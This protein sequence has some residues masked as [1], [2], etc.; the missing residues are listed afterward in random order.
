GTNP[1][2]SKILAAGIP[3]GIGYTI[4]SGGEVTFQAMAPALVP[5]D[6]TRVVPFLITADTYVFHP[7]VDHLNVL[8]GATS[9]DVDGTLDRTDLP[10][11][12]LSGADLQ[13]HDGT[14]SETLTAVSGQVHLLLGD[15][16]D[17][18]WIVIVDLDTMQR[19]TSFTLVDSDTI[20]GLTSGH[21]YLVVYAT[22][23][24]TY[25]GGEIVYEVE[26]FVNPD[27]G[28][29]DARLVVVYHEAGDLVYDLFTGDPVYGWNGVQLQY[30]ANDPVR[31]FRGEAVRHYA[32]EIRRY[33]GGH[34]DPDTLLPTGEPIIDEDG[35][36]VVNGDGTIFTA[37]PG[38]AQ[39]H[40]REEKRVD[41]VVF[42][43]V[44]RVTLGAT[45]SPATTY[46]LGDADVD[47]NDFNGVIGATTAMTFRAANST[48]GHLGDGVVVVIAR[49]QYGTFIVKTTDWEFER[50]TGTLRVK[51]SGQYTI[52]G[53]TYDAAEIG[54]V[55]LEV[56]TAVQRFHKAGDVVRYFG[57]EA[58]VDFQP[59]V[60]SAGELVTI[61]GVVVLWTDDPSDA[62]IAAGT[63]RFVRTTNGNQI[64]HRRGEP[65]YVCVGGDAATGCLET[66]ATWQVAE[67]ADGDLWLR[68]GNEAR[69]WFGG[70]QAL[71]AANE[72]R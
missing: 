32:G 5:V 19:A 48:L 45:Y 13:Y 26:L 72:L 41:V 4:A 53:R 25:F 21:D 71:Y 17:A 58:V 49:S 38:Q 7:G 16:V 46:L 68:L 24:K 34:I 27:T 37:A 15:A 29:Q 6:R 64:F 60:N 65:V 39:I 12:D 67:H 54:E 66:G 47:A 8:G 62:G 31:R 52:A 36:V 10:V 23:R 42:R 2:G 30:T 50:S 20:G 57:D 14:L 61:D 1:D 9:G 3:D 63:K 59:V 44:G 43:T 11:P 35:D 40:D 56:S 55:D 70:E 33:L 69:R 51:L 22:A 28:Q 18:N